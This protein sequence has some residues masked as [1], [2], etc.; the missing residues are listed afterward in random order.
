MIYPSLGFW[1]HL[2]FPKEKVHSFII[3]ASHLRLRFCQQSEQIS[4][5]DGR[6]DASGG[7]RDAARKGAQEPLLR[8]SLFRALTKTAVT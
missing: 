3:S 5:Q 7:G 4:K 1:G 2:F 6:G 8:H